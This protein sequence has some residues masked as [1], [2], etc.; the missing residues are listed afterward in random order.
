VPHAWCHTPSRYDTTTLP[1]YWKVAHANATVDPNDGYASGP[2]L[3]ASA[4]GAYVKDE[5]NDI[6]DLTRGG[7]GARI[8]V[9]SAPASES[10]LLGL[11]DANLDL[12][13]SLSLLPD[14]RVAV[15]VGELE[16]LVAISDIADALATAS[17]LRLGCKVDFTTGDVEVWLDDVVIASGTHAGLVG[18]QWGGVYVGCHSNIYTSHVYMRAGYELTPDA[19]ILT[20]LSAN[21]DL[22]DSVP[23]GDTTAEVLTQI[24]DSFTDALASFSAKSSWYGL[25]I[26]SLVKAVNDPNGHSVVANVDGQDYIGP[27]NQMDVGAYRS[28]QLNLPTNPRTSLPWTSD[29][30][31]DLLRPGGMAVA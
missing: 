27:R 5:V 6:A 14:L 31:A 16:E 8:K 20:I 30:I 23:D 18:L 2:A 4:L 11:T 15:Y 24:G 10:I 9:S 3:T 19:L 7:I 13:A 25:T 28:A 22:D 26:Q 21:A 17:Q 29:D 12:V 1:L